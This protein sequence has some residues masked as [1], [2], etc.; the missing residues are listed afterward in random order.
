MNDARI[1]PAEAQ[2]LTILML[3]LGI[4]AVFVILV[5]DSLIALFLGAVFSALAYPFYTKVTSWL[6][7]RK[8]PA[9]VLTLLILILI[10][11]IP[12]LVLLDL[13]AVQAYQ[14]TQ[15]AVP[16]LEKSLENPEDLS[17][18]IPDWVPFRDK[19][20]GSGPQIAAK[21]GELAGKVGGFLV[22]GLSAATTGAA[23]FFLSIFV[24]LYAMFFF[25]RSG[26]PLV[27][28]LM[29]YPPLSPEIQ[30]RLMEKGLSVTRATI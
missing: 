11:L 17:I 30:N 9:A 12:A 21:L 20:D 2:K 16:W 23:G 1:R 26:P 14:L 4:T 19:I 13:I 10:V 8:G 18:P 25:L 3:T 28:K 15:E 5:S 7:G 6:G 27:E 29:T 22:K 24:M